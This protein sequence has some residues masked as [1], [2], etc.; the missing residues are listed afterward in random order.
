MEFSSSGRFLTEDTYTGSESDPLS[1]NR[2]I[3]AR[4][5]PES[6]SDPSG[7]MF[8][9]GSGGGSPSDTGSGANDFLTCN[10]T[11]CGTVSGGTD[12]GSMTT[13]YGITNSQSCGYFG[14]LSN[15][16]N[17]GGPQTG[18]IIGHSQKLPFLAWFTNVYAPENIG[19]LVTTIAGVAAAWLGLRYLDFTAKDVTA[20]LT[21]TLLGNLAESAETAVIDNNAAPL[22][23]TISE[24]TLEVIGQTVSHAGP[25]VFVGLGFSGGT[26]ILGGFVPG[27][28]EGRAAV[29]LIVS[30][31]YV[32]D[33]VANILYQWNEYNN[34]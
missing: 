7:H 9:T 33:L 4:D 23:S 12:P 11:G 22:G 28:D 3:Y 2:Y 30:T 25:L 13:G 18:K 34:S 24:L 14:C 32:G 15:A 29:S 6:L 20:V 31:Y 27:L 17:A 16:D 21:T 5:N 1:L 8:T 26:W 10:I 19:E